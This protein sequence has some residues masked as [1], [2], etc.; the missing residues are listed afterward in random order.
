MTL[1]ES[2]PNTDLRKVLSSVEALEAPESLGSTLW[3]LNYICNKFN[4][5]ISQ[6]SFEAM[7]PFPPYSLSKAFTTQYNLWKETG[8]IMCLDAADSLLTMLRHFSKRWMRAG[9][10]NLN[11]FRY[12]SILIK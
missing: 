9:K 3:R 8:D 4:E 2:R 11:T 1:H 7:S 5:N 10:L 6:V 12:N